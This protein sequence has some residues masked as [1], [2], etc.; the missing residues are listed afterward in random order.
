MLT[1]LKNISY[2][3]C[4][5]YFIIKLH[6]YSSYLHNR[7]LVAAYGY[8]FIELIDCNP[9]LIGSTKADLR[10]ILLMDC[11]SFEIISKDSLRLWSYQLLSQRWVPSLPL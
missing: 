2:I 1:G 6:L 4:L 9:N 5:C 11:I 7:S 8:T 10:D 3:S